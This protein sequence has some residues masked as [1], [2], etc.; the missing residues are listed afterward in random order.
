MIK[1]TLQQTL[2]KHDITANQ[3]AQTAK[4]RPATIYNI[5]SN[6]VKS[7]SFETLTAIITTLRELT[8]DDIDVND[9]FVYQDD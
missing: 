6:K 9:V 4:I 2:D 1:I 3:L 7:I 5:I 8:D